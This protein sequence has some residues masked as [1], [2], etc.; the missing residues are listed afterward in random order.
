VSIFS[1]IWKLAP[2][3]PRF[4]HYLPA[5]LRLLLDTSNTTLLDVR[6]VLADDS[7]RNGLLQACDDPET[8]QTWKEFNAKKEQQQ[9]QEIGGL[10]N[11]VAAL[12]DPL[13]LR[14][15]LCQPTSTLSITNLLH[16]CLNVN[17]IDSIG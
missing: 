13:P 7:Y 5:A 12:A 10:Q 15:I 9:A 6:R 16:W 8:L 11:K 1:D 3:T 4:L 14:Y 17:R 2:E